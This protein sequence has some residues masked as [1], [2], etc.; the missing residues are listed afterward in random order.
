M[1]AQRSR[2]ETH[3]RHARAVV[4][5]SGG[6]DSAA[7][8][9]ISREHGLAVSALFVD[10]GQPAA[11]VERAYSAAL[12]TAFEIDWREV[13]V[14]GLACPDEGEVAGRNALLIA[15]A[16]NVLSGAGCLVLGIHGGTGY[17]DCTEDFLVAQQAQLD[18][19]TGGAVRLVCP[20]VAWSK[21]D[22]LSLARD[23]GVRPD[24]TYSCERGA[25]P[26]CGKCRSCI[27]R[28]DWSASA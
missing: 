8:A 4:L 3:Q 14:T 9:L 19:Q 1:N 6:V 23:L 13:S 28:R 15:V 25:Q 20:F 5:M 17:P 18:A 2:G 26:P 7:A 22:V 27:D 16:Q 11:E 10:Y 24:R 12:A 21:V